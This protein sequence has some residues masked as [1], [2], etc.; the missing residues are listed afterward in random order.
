[1]NGPRSEW[2][3]MS[4]W[5]EE[6]EAK[7]IRKERQRAILR[8]AAEDRLGD[9]Q[10]AE[11]LLKSRQTPPT[12]SPLEI[13][14]ALVSNAQLK[15]SEFGPYLFRRVEVP[16]DTSTDAIPSL[17]AYEQITGE[18]DTA[19]RRTG[20]SAP[21]A[22]KR[23]RPQ[24]PADFSDVWPDDLPEPRR[25]SRVEADAPP[26]DA[27]DS[28]WP[29]MDIEDL[30]RFRRALDRARM[31][32][33]RRENQPDPRE[34]YPS[35]AYQCRSGTPLDAT[36]P[37]T[38]AELVGG[39]TPPRDL[40]LEQV[41]FVDTETTGLAGGTGT[42]PFLIGVGYLEGIA[43]PHPLFIVEQYFM[44]DYCYEEAALAAVLARLK[45]FAA[46]CTYNG[47]TFDIPLLQ[48]RCIFHRRPPSVW[49]L[50]HLDLLHMA[51]RL[52]R[53]VLPK[54]SLGQVENSVLGHARER[55]VEGAWIPRI[56]FQYARGRNPERL[57][58]VFDHNVQD[59]ASLGALLPRIC[60]Y[61]RNPQHPALRHPREFI[62]L[63]LWSE[64][65]GRMDAAM[66]CF[67]QAI[68]LSREPDQQDSLLAHLGRMHKRAGRWA[69]AVDAWERLLNRPMAV[70]LR[71]AVELAKYW[72]HRARNPEKAREVVLAAM[73][74]IEADQ[75]GR[76]LLR[77]K[78]ASELR[79]SPTA[80]IESLAHRL[81]RLEKRVR[82]KKPADEKESMFE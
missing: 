46:L 81:Q 40:R 15:E 72:E 75:E 44:T 77:R 56:Y 26:A 14:T 28:N 58:P 79:K 61:L 29:D 69:E 66:V 67:E 71:A 22:R 70:S 8:A 3:V 41:L 43:T 47:K 27:P 62:G 19:D 5:R 31:R 13:L 63:G 80:W 68:Q 76:A 52:W 73:S 16:V 1:M 45:S 2:V 64:R 74:R 33:E 42:Y 60:A 34:T 20:V 21:A 48:T 9:I 35:I 18:T 65:H 59:I 54:V 38:L 57:V 51:R 23:S 7:R 37:E 24:R 6:F 4:D 32:R 10:T 82:H 39:P 17:E 12:Q 50:P 78:D 55:D 11:S 49:E 53:G 25:D 36:A 30:P